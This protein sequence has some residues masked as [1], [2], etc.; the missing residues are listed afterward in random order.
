MFNVIFSHSTNILS[1]Q[2]FCYLSYFN[3]SK[4]S[5]SHVTKGSNTNLHN[6][7]FSLQD[8]IRYFALDQRALH[9]TVRAFNAHRK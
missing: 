8:V 5:M 3:I 1:Y 2:N 6:I 9:S 4:I 7:L